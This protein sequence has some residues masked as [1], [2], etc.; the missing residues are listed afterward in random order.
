[1]A[2]PWATAYISLDP[3]ESF[4]MWESGTFSAII[5]VRRE[6]EYVTG[7]I[8]GAVFAKELNT[9]TV[10]P[11]SLIGC[12]NCTVGVYCKSGSRSKKAAGILENAGFVRVYDMLGVKQLIEE[13]DAPFVDYLEVGI[14]EVAPVA[15]CAANRT[16]ATC[17]V[18]VLPTLLAFSP[19]SGGS[20]MN[21][22]FK[23]KSLWV[24]GAVLSFTSTYLV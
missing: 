2:S 1:V 9:A 7:H 5:D 4:A 23:L 15:P 22:V 14:P 18:E 19:T 20:S 13:G 21:V 10:V 16:N 17:S 6:D 8:I 11:S 12:E 3:K 24:L